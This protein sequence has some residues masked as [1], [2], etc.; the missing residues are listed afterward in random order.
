M[1]QPVLFHIARDGETLGSWTGLDIRQFLA[2]GQLLIT[3]QYYDEG[4]Q[5]WR[6]FIPSPKRRTLQFDWQ[7]EDDD[8]WFYIKDGFIHGPRHSEEID[9]LHASGFL[10][11]N[12]LLSFVGA[13]SWFT[14]TDVVPPQPAQADAEHLDAA[15]LQLKQGNLLSAAVNFGAFLLS[16]P[17][18]PTSQTEGANPN[19]RR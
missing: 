11:P 17:N 1:E 15:K 9:A 5:T 8:L 16:S 2:N 12:S 14:Y 3:D 6:P 19:R 4:A 10:P 13:E 18:E 7:G